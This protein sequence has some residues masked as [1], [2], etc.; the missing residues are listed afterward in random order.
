MTNVNSFLILSWDQ[1]LIGEREG[2]KLLVERPKADVKDSG[3]GGTL[4]S[5]FCI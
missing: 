4:V 5:Q 1:I 2:G 3:V